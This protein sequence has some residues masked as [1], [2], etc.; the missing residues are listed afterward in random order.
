M[1][2]KSIKK[3]I[4]EQVYKKYDGHC[5]YCGCELEF[6]DM[7]CDHLFSV[8]RAHGMY[9][10]INEIDNLMPSCR[11][12]NYYKN[13]FTLEQFRKE[14]STIM[15]RVRKPL[16]YRLAVKYGMV[17]ETKWDGKFYFE[18][19]KDINNEQGKNN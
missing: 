19:L 13:T 8:Y 5:A 3:S 17:E 4:R 1:E 2:R 16:N 18:R 9:D 11:Q 7:Q 12:C 14:L 15:E 6:K 10:N